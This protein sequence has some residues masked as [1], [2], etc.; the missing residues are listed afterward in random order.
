[1]LRPT[2][3]D[4]NQTYPHG[5]IKALAAGAADLYDLGLSQFDG[6][7]LVGMEL[8][9]WMLGKGLRRVA[10]IESPIG[11]TVPVQFIAA[12]AKKRGLAVEILQWNAPRNDRTKR[13]RTVE[14]SAAVCGAETMR[15]DL[16]VLVDE[17]LTGTRFLKLFDALIGPIGKN[18]LHAA[19]DFSRNVR[20]GL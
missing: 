5:L 12:L 15:F 3:F 1:M 19:I 10:L 20:V 9:E 14:E 6:L 4:P 16:V 13:G 17:C 2:V 8:V 7:A 11:N 18:R